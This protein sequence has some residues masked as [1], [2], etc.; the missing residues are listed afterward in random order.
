MSTPRY[1]PLEVNIALLAHVIPSVSVVCYDCY[2]QRIVTENS[3]QV[4]VQLVTNE[5]EPNSCHPYTGSFS[6]TTII[7]MVKG[8]ATFDNLQGVCKQDA[9]VQYPAFGQD[10]LRGGYFTTFPVLFEWRYKCWSGLH[11]PFES[12]QM[13]RRGSLPGTGSVESQC[14]RIHRADVSIYRHLSRDQ[15]HRDGFDFHK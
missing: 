15:Q 2:G 14:G 8:V 6:G 4:E 1:R 9:H 12:S 7:T 3:L 11:L 10:K 13:C 5:I